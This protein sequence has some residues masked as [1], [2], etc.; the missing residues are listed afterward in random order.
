MKCPKCLHHF[1]VK[2]VKMH[3]PGDFNPHCTLCGINTHPDEAP[4]RMAQKL[5]ELDC[6]TCRR[7]LMAQ[8]AL[9][10]GETTRKSEFP[11]RKAQA[12]ARNLERGEYLERSGA[13]QLRLSRSFR[14]HSR[15]HRMMQLLRKIP[16]MWG[17]L[18]AVYAECVR[19][20]VY[21]PRTSFRD[22]Q[23]PLRRYVALA[24]EIEGNL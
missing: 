1:R 11:R 12:D 14:N 3:W 23:A 16:H 7:M 21:S 10:P 22:V 18:E 17:D 15:T 8:G 4:A 6:T 5:S 20:K 13:K 2:D 19:R 9:L 24:K